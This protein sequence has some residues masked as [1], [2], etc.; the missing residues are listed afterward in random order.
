MTDDNPLYAADLV[1]Q[2]CH[3]CDSPIVS[4]KALGCVC[5]KHGY[6]QHD[7]E[8]FVWCSENCMLNDHPEA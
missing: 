4:G 6:P 5:A 1:E 8:E 7:R 3:Y 2:T